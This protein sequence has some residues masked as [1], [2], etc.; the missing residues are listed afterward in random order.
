M[1]AKSLL[2]PIAAF[3]LTVTGA[4]AFNGQILQEAG[5][6]EDQIVAF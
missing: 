5:L 2:I 4:Q 6:I 3:A 1:N